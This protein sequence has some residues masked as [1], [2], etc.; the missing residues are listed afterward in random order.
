MLSL[1]TKGC[2]S[3]RFKF[4]RQNISHPYVDTFLSVIYVNYAKLSVICQNH[5]NIKLLLIFNIDNNFLGLR[6]LF[7]NVYFNN[8]QDFVIQRVH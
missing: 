2:K 1:I 6:N 8:S 3:K 4:I 5:K 7:K